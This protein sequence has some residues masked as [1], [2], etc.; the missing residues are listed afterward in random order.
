MGTTADKLAKL[1]ETKSAL[2]AALAEKGQTVGDVFSTYPDAVKAIETGPSL[3]TATVTFG[4]SQ[5]STMLSVVDSNMEYKRLES[6]KPWISPTTE[7]V[8]NVPCIITIDYYST[9][10]K[11]SVTGQC[12]MIKSIKDAEMGVTLSAYLVTGDTQVSVG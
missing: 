9:S 7:I 10:Y 8:V 4:A 11:E 1:Q 3:N 5:G 6:P 2:K 12:T